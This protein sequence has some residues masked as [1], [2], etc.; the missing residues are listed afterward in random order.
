MCVPVTVECFIGRLLRKERASEIDITCLVQNNV[1]VCVCVLEAC[2]HS[3]SVCVCVCVC[4]FGSL[5]AQF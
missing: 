5:C 3:F 2:V 4:V 1:C